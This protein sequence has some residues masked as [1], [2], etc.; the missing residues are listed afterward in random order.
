MAQETDIVIR[1]FKGTDREAV[2]DIT[3]NTAFMGEPASVFFDDREVISDALSLYFTDYEPESCFVAEANL[4]V[5]GSLIGA[6]SKIKAEKTFKHQIALS[7]LVKA[8]KRGTFT[9]RANRRFI[10]SCL[11]SLISGG[12]NSPDFTKEYPAT[13]HININNGFR[14]LNIG[15]K[16]VNAYLGYLKSQKVSGVHLATMSDLGAKFFYRQGFSLLYKGKRSYFRPI[17][18]QDV[19]LYIFGKAIEPDEP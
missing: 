14:G 19:P 17:L 16:L 6:K 2:R 5:I 12:L 15:T 7:L 9:K 18:H 10:F 4:K 13:L 1:K 3:F 11:L 8:F